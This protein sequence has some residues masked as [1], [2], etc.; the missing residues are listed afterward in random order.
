MLGPWSDGMVCVVFHRV[1]IKVKVAG[2]GP[3]L[4][5]CCWVGGGGCGLGRPVCWLILGRRPD[6]IRDW[7]A[8]PF[9]SANRTVAAYD[10]AELFFCPL[11]Y[12]CCGLL[13]FLDAGG[14]QL[15]G[16]WLP[17]DYHLGVVSLDNDADG[18]W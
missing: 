8:L 5:C 14:E 6:G 18:G 16:W 12:S 3:T 11:F 10:G 17:F 7:W 9:H 2:S 4:R 15:R 1:R 13:G